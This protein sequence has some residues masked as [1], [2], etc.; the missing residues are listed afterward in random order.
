MRIVSGNIKQSP[1]VRD[2]TALLGGAASL[3]P[4]TIPTPLAP[5]HRTTDLL[6]DQAS[7]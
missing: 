1:A 5:P 3:P 4:Y 6:E 7:S 2:A